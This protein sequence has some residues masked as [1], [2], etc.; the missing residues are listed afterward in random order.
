MK[1]SIR[2][3]AVVTLFLVGLAAC[4]LPFGQPIEVD[5]N[6]INTSVAQTLAALGG[7]AEATASIAL[8]TVTS[9]PLPTAALPTVAPTVVP[10]TAAPTQDTCNQAKWVEDVTVPDGSVYLPNVDFTKTWRLQNV[11]TCTWNTSYAVVYSGGDHM[12][13]PAATSLLGNVPPGATVDLSVKMKSPA[14]NGEYT[15]NFMLRSDTGLLF[16]TG[17]SFNA[18]I[19][20]NIKVNKI[21]LLLPTLD[22][23]GIM[24]IFPL[25]TLVYNF[26]AN[27]CSADWMNASGGDLDCPGNTS[28]AAGYVV[29][30]DDPKLSDGETYNGVAILTHPQWVDGGS[31]GG[32]FPQFTVENGM[33]FRATLGCRYNGNACDV[34][35]YLRYYEQGVSG[36]KQITYWDIKYSD[37]PLAVDV[38]LSGLAG[39]NIKI[40]LQVVTNGSPNQDWA[41]WVNPRI[42]K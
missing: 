22:L 10:P 13:E 28:D 34:R 32:S 40:L 36:L 35:Y 12:G 14:E 30:Y 2:Y 8:P 29:R 19:F 15:T 31:I 38:D 33:K 20:A 37:T 26:A 11:G 6:A 16:G 17:S 9:M 27:Y 25:E 1:A 39:K 4:S 5:E 18:P 3:I 24:P 23:G 42:V 41:Q 7:A 21:M